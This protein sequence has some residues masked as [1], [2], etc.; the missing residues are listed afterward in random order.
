MNQFLKFFGV[1]GFVVSFL[2]TMTFAQ[3]LPRSGNDAIWA[4]STA[5]AN[6]TLDGNLNE[7][8]WM[9]AETL[10]IVYGQSSGLPTS[11]WQIEFQNPTDPTNAMV[12]FL[13]TPDN[14]LWL[15]FMVPDSSVGGIQDWARWDGIIMSLKDRNSSNRPSDPSEFFYTWWYV[16]VD[17]LINPG[18][19]PRFIG[20]WGNFGDTT[21]TAGQR[22][23]WDARTVVNGMSND[24]SSPDDGYTVE[25]R[26]SLDSLGYDATNPNGD[27]IELNFSIWDGDWLFAGDPS[28]ISENRTDWQSP[29]NANLHNVG[30]VYV[31]PDV[32][33]NS[34]PVPTIGPDVRLPNGINQPAPTIDGDLSDP[35]WSLAYTFD[36]RWDDAALR[37]SYPGVGPYRSGQFQPDVN[38]GKAP[39]VDPGDA[40]IKMFFRGSHLYLAADVRDQ[41]VEGTT[42]FD[43]MDGV[44]FM[45][46]DR[47]S[48]DGD[49]RSVIWQ[50]TVSFD[51]SGALVGIDDMPYLQTQGTVQYGYALK[52]ST[53]VNNNNDVDEG[54]IVEMDVDLTG[55][56][57]P[58]D[59][60]D[61]V[62][63]AGV[64]L[65]D[66]DSFQDPA[67]DYGARTWW[68]R[69]GNFGPAA[70]WVFM[71]E[72]LTAI[73]DPAENALPNTLRLF[74]NY[75]NPFNPTTTISYSLPFSGKT[76]IVIY[77]LLGQEVERIGNLRQ[78]A[79]EHFIVFNANNLA[80]GVYFYKIF[81][82][83]PGNNK[84]VESRANKMVLLK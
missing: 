8:A 54:F 10:P 11:G 32:T 67:N 44:R 72:T 65:M 31:R 69:E 57:Y 6:L 52:G 33:I 12:K 19:P 42:I 9:Q 62:L 37:D 26:I 24:D 1:T 39:I 43:Q 46:A 66:G 49:H 2:A 17:S 38:G 7:A 40:T 20:R 15:G 68:F 16:N 14:Y 21:R 47:D 73:N 18:A 81:L 55:M 84:I 45:I 83:N 35:Y 61:H 75:P 78:S 53:T 59:L 70:A 50:L 4:R 79:G 51:S 64:M 48:M 13:V 41:L 22:A 63:F 56:G 25:M 34:G 58:A 76:E 27:V 28:R 3:S 82:T 30:R 80:S 71:D 23:A 29:W 74:G 77:N 36:I 60:G 5:G